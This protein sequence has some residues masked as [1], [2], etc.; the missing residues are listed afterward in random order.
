[1]KK[2]LIFAVLFAAASL[3]AQGPPPGRGGGRM[4]PGGPGPGFGVAPGM[5]RT[6]TGAPYSAVEVTETTQTLANG[7]VI[8]HKSQSN[9]YR[10]SMGRVRVETTVPARGGTAGQT[11]TRIT[12]HDPVAGVTRELDPQAKTVREMTIPQGRGPGGNG[13]RPAPQGRMMADAARRPEPNA[14]TETLA[15]QTINGIQANGTRMTRTIPAG[16]IGNAQ[17]I[18]TVRETWVSPDLKV[19]V[20]VKTVDPRFGATTTQ[21]TNIIR[22][23]P[24]ASLFQAPADYTVTH[25]TGRPGMRG[26]GGGQIR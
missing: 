8:Q 2:S 12:I 23:E 11:M 19:P 16:E 7:N 3:L 6:V 5:M 4:G 17:P 10:D 14:V 26:P 18:Q 21:L 24:D 20:M 25:V 13:G 15:M 1:M 9:V 22:S